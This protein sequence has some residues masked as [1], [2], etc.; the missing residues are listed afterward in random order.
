M[1]VRMNKPQL[2]ARQATMWFVMYYVGS[3]YLILPSSMV[4][5]ARQDAWLS[6]LFAL[7]IH[8]LLIPLYV[9]IAKQMKGKSPVLYFGTLLGKRSSQC[10]AFLFLLFV[11]FLIF[12]LTLRNLGDFISTSIMPETPEE[13]VYALMLIA[14]YFIVRAGPAV[15]GRSAETLFLV[16]PLLFFLVVISLLPNAEIKH[17]LPVFEYGWKPIVRSSFLFLAFPYLE[18]FLFL[19]LCPHL[20][21]PRIWKKALLHS[22]LIS[23]SLYVGMILLVITVLGESVASELTN[24]SYFVV[25]TINIGDFIQRFEI[26]VTIFWYITIFFRLTL[27][28][29]ITVHGLGAVFQLQDGT[30]LLI[31]LLL[32]ALIMAHF[33]WPN[34]AF[35]IEFFQAWPLY[36]MVF[37]I[38]L[39]LVIWL[40]GRMKQTGSLGMRR[41]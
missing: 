31:P 5:I 8:L 29:F 40:L 37:G 28:I 32:I 19:F 39:P 10:F 21:E 9:A 14:V 24:S 20:G 30:S 17:L 34:A 36:A 11:P 35:L 27:L 33:M 41:R 22:S 2:S 12:I 4:K 7:A 38:A 3:A 15:I 6:C 18:T 25:R 16:I 1:E 26:V 23:F 13:A